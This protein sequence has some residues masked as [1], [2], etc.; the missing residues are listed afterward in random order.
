MSEITYS[1]EALNVL[2]KFHRV[3]VA[4]HV[5]GEDD[6]VF[7]QKVFELITD[8]KVG[9]IS[10]GGSVELDRRIKLIEAGSL[11]AIAARDSDYH[12]LR[13]IA[14][15]SPRVLY[16]YGYSIENTLYSASTVAD[17]SKISCRTDNDLFTDTNNWKN[18]FANSFS[19]LL[20]LDL[21]NDIGNLGMS[22]LGDNCSRYMEND[23]SQKP[24][25]LKISA[26]EASTL[27]QLN[28]NSI[29]IADNI[30][31]VD[32]FDSWRWLRGHFVASGVQKYISNAAKDVGRRTSIAHDHIFGQAIF[33]VHKVFSDDIVQNSHYH[34]SVTA[35]LA[36]F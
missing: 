34:T 11:D 29:A 35:A 21:A 5:E 17:I 31:N 30:L 10:A 15:D 23:S 9:F 3:A 13:N 18:L 27:A 4:V 22:V 33:C 16:S 24:C 1:L 6:I 20:R 26:K 36:T 12:V 28:A 8:R 2:N 19:S 7:W 25:T 14:S 32:E